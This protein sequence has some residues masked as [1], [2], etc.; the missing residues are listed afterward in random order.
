M[1]CVG[2]IVIVQANEVPHATYLAYMQCVTLSA[3][4][5]L[6]LAGNIVTSCFDNMLILAR[7]DRKGNAFKETRF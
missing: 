1:N 5:K 6:A 3:A 2:R 4:N 7:M